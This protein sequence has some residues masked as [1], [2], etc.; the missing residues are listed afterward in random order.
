M[1]DGALFTLVKA[2]LDAGFA[3]DYPQ[4]GEITVKQSYQPRTTGAPSGNSVLLSQGVQRRYGFMRRANVWVPAV[5]P[6]P[7]Y[8]KRT[9]TQMWEATFQCDALVLAPPQPKALAPYTSGDICSA[10]SWILQGDVGRAALFA[11]GCGVYRV[12]DIRSPYFQNEQGQFQQSPSFDFTLSYEEVRTFT[13]PIVTS[14]I[15]RIKGV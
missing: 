14:E 8:M 12:T 1:N 4:F 15:W 7:A 11:G 13:T 10:A 3:A 6:T 2:T 9:E 5:G